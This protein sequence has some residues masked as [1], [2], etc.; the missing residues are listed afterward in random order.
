MKEAAG[1]ERVHHRARPRS[2]VERFM[3]PAPDL[4]ADDLG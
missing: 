1:G 4:K 2:V 3:V